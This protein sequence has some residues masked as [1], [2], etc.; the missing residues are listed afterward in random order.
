MDAGVCANATI[1][2]RCSKRETRNGFKKLIAEKTLVREK[3]SKMKRN[4]IEINLI[5]GDVMVEQGFLQE[6]ETVKYLSGDE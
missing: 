3:A 4:K 6:E 2:G 5:K 1:K